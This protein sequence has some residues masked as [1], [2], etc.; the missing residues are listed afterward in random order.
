M[1]DVLLVL[2]EFHLQR[3]RRL[4]Q[5]RDRGEEVDAS[6]LPEQERS[7]RLAAVDDERRDKDVRVEDR[8]HQRCWNTSRSTCRSVKMPFALARRAILR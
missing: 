1:L 5:D 3:S 6:A 8:S 4:C 7:L 2:V